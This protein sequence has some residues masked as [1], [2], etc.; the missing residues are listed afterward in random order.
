[1]SLLNNILRILYVHRTTFIIGNIPEGLCMFKQH[2]Q[3]AGYHTSLDK[4]LTEGTE[5]PPVRF[6][7]ISATREI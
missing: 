3:L 4:M 7:D 1:M 6:A 5:R 2:T